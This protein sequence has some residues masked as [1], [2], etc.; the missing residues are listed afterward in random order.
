VD[1]QPNNATALN[2]LAWVSAQLKDPKAIDYAE[3]ANRL[4]P[5]QPSIM[6]TLA[7]LLVEKGDTSRAIQ[8]LRDAVKLAPSEPALRLSLAKALIKADQKD[9]A[10]KELEELA[11]LGDKFKSQADVERMLKGL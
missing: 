8:L 6:D 1:L 4:A 5:N 2:N 11:K 9:A 10:R 3:K 7:M